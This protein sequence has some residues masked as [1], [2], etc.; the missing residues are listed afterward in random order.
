[1]ISMRILLLTLLS[2]C[3]PWPAGALGL[4]Q[5][6]VPDLD[7]SRSH[8]L[9]ELDGRIVGGG[10]T[11]TASLTA[12]GIS[13][14]A[15]RGQQAESTL[16]LN[17]HLETVKRGGWSRSFSDQAVLPTLEGQRAIY[18]HPNLIE[19]YESR[20]AGLEQHF[21]FSEEP[22]GEGDLLVALS[23]ESTLTWESPGTWADEQR[24]MQGGEALLSVRGVLGIDAGGRT[25]AG[26]VLAE[27]GRLWLRLPAEFIDNAAYPLVLDPLIGSPGDVSTALD[28]TGAAVAF[29]PG[30]NQFL[31]VWSVEVS[32]TQADVR[33]QVLDVLG[34]P[35][36]G[37]ITV[38]SFLGEIR[39][40]AVVGTFRDAGRFLV[41]YRR[42]GFFLGPFGLEARSILPSGTVSPSTLILPSTDA[43]GAEL[44]LGS[45]AMT[46][47]GDSN[48]LFCSV[49]G[50]TLTGV[51]LVPNANGWPSVA[52]S[53]IVP[54]SQ[55]LFGSDQPALPRTGGSAGLYLL[56]WRSRGPLVDEVR[57]VVVNR[58]GALLTPSLTTTIAN[59]SVLRPAVDGYPTSNSNARWLLAAQTS[60]S[61][62]SSDHDVRAWAY[63][64]NGT[65]L[66]LN[67]G[68]LQVDA[69]LGVD[70]VEPAVL[71]MGAKAFVSWANEGGSLDYDILIKGVDPLTCVECEPISAVSN[72]TGLN[73]AP[74]LAGELP[75]NGGDGND[76]ALVLW[77]R[78]AP[79]LP[80]SGDIQYR[81]IQLAA[82]S[83]SAV[84]QGGGCGGGG[85]L[86][87]SQNPAIGVGA[88]ACTLTGADP[89][90]PAAILN[91][92]VNGAALPISCGACVLEPYFLTVTLPVVAGSSAVTLAVP[93]KTTAIGAQLI[94]Q[95]TV[96]LTSASPCSIAANVS[97]SDRLLVTIGS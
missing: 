47:Q 22:A 5:Q 13:V 2:W 96:L 8:G 34:A 6:T 66:A 59:I 23:A 20:T 25:S 60:E 68:P 81:A 9:S 31:A 53:P 92:A 79:Q 27:A 69:N 19:W 62:G 16:S 10:H 63:T 38:A 29:H 44:A 45:E 80:F 49:N 85:S 39:R 61:P 14:A 7:L 18:T 41:A 91:I 28:A 57:S 54:P 36:G 58:N 24:L 37:L 56:S 74:A 21:T 51:R 78:I 3:T 17:L 64:F 30:L 67:A 87:V 12:E 89:L 26:E 70:E 52:G 65:A 93:C 40:D 50:A 72:G 11:W 86:G 35:V 77:D 95:W 83:G 82:Q 15:I 1:V 97:L 46:G 88:F 76:R 4:A 84:S 42:A 90:A 94:A 48:L 71:W 75:S 55:S 43:V 32:L 73:R 33:A